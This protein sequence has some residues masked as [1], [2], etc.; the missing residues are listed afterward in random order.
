LR[1]DGQDC[2]FEKG[3]VGGPQGSLQ[4][5]WDDMREPIEDDRTEPEAPASEA[6]RRQA[7]QEPTLQRLSLSRT[8]LGGGPTTDGLETFS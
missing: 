3:G 8:E 4:Q 7:W 6:R 5:D 1:C 2:S